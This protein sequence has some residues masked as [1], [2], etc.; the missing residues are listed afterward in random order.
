M[1]SNKLLNKADHGE[2]SKDNLGSNNQMEVD[3]TGVIRNVGVELKVEI[4]TMGFRKWSSNIPFV[5]PG[6]EPF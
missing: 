1:S 3:E 6:G 2:F 5:V 4:I